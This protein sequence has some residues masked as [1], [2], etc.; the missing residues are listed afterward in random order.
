MVNW[1]PSRSV[2][3]EQFLP[4][5]Q[6]HSLRT[7]K[8]LFCL[9]TIVYHWNR[10]SRWRPLIG[11]WAGVI[12]RRMYQYLSSTSAQKKSTHF[13][14]CTK[15]S[16]NF[17]ELKLILV[18]DGKAKLEAFETMMCIMQVLQC[19]HLKY[20]VCA[21]CLNMRPISWS[22]GQAAEQRAHSNQ[23]DSNCRFGLETD[24]ESSERLGSEQTSVL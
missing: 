6:I 23:A 2:S 5:S 15:V 4:N 20:M 19:L 8:N 10:L 18:A 3:K 22:D 17:S 7:F 12:R 16:C 14:S 11:S 24:L 21:L 13:I 9:C 1:R